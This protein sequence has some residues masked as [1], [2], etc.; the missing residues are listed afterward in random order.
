MS[1]EEN[2]A[3]IHREVDDF[4]N[5][6][7]LDVI[8]EIFGAD[9]VG[10]GPGSSGSLEEFKLSAAAL[11]AAFESIHVTIEDLIV[12]GDTV[13]KRWTATSTHAGEYMGIPPTGNQVQFTGIYIFRIAEGKIVEQWVEA[14]WLGFMQQLGA[15][16]PMGGEG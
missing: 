1:L 13:V 12:E 3:L 6:G 16:P 8:D 2:R 9:Y 15:I 10:H 4:W 14:D 11:F 7:N 5:T